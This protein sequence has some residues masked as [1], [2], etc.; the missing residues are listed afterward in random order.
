MPLPAFLHRL[1]EEKQGLLTFEDYMGVALYHPEGGYYSHTVSDIGRHGD[2]TTAPVLHPVVGKAVAEWASAH[3]HKL[4][5][6]RSWHIIE[7]GGGNGE[8]AA[9]L[10]RHLSLWERFTLHY[11]IVEVSP[12]LRARQQE[13][14]GSRVQWHDTV[15]GAL[16]AAGRK[17]LIFSN[18]LVD[19]F[20]CILL[21]RGAEGWN[22]VWLKAEGGEL[23][24]HL[25][26]LSPDRLRDVSSSALRD[27]G[28]FPV[29]QRIELHAAYLRWM[30]EWL[31]SFE[32]GLL[33]TIDYGDVLSK[34]YH[35]R[36]KGTLRSYYQQWVFEGT[37]CYRRTGRQDI[38]ADINFSDLI[39]WG[40]RLGL[41]VAGFQTQAEFLQEWAP[42]NRRAIEGDA[43]L[44]MVL[45]PD[46]AGHAF[47]V[48][49]QN[50][51]A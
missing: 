20:P 34:L 41:P 31:P 9:S 44:G 33:L 4:N 49:I 39:E 45:N 5:S 10:L 42:K 47:K 7:V 24:E 30:K 36:P 46:G 38:T 35:R 25:R 27:H 6:R 1:L 8:L 12:G 22:E 16:R 19:A 23:K 28:N 50:R 3:R 43:R 18:E 2:F 11:H 29:G 15:A 14:L 51:N 37:D 40:D 17:A 13:R 21:E 26:P 32:Q 48:L